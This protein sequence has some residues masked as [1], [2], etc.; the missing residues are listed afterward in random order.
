MDNNILLSYGGGGEEMNKFIKDE[1]FKLFNNEILLKANDAAILKNL[2][3]SS[4]SFVVSPIFFSGGDIGK[5]SVCGSVNDVLMVGAN[6]KYLSLSL[7]IEEGF[8]K[9]DLRKILNSIKLEASKNDVLVVC[10]DTKV[11]PKSK[12]DKIFINTTCLGEIVNKVDSNDIKEGDSILLSGDIGRHGAVIMAAR[13][14]I[15]LSSGLKSDCKSLKKEVLDL[16]NSGIKPNALRDATRGGLSAVLNE[17]SE[18][19][20]LRFEVEEEKI[21]ICDEVFGICELLGLNALDLANEGTFVA[22]VDKKDEQKALEILKKYNSFAS[23]I[24]KVTKG[25]GVVIKS[26]YGSL[27]ILEYPKGEL[28]PRIC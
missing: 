20:R 27:R 21:K 14:E 22:V 4:D 24:G 3:I 10:G 11:V 28:L 8:S 26:T 5:I 1:I 13:D 2:A 19:N 23:V 7:I 15:N 16:L 18:Q 25:E 6:P 12:A 9:E 17:L